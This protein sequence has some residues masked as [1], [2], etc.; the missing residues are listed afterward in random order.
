MARQEYSQVNIVLEQGEEKGHAGLD[1][2]A[3]QSFTLSQF[4]VLLLL[5]FI[6]PFMLSIRTA[7]H[8]LPKQQ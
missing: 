3:A 2:R 8:A 4:E 6:N 5:H 1:C 7:L